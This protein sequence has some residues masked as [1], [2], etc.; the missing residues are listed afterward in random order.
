MI[1][2]S[3]PNERVSVPPLIDRDQ[4]CPF[5]LKTYVSVT[6]K[7]LPINYNSAAFNTFKPLC[8]YSWRDATLDELT[9]LLLQSNNVYN[10]VAT[11]TAPANWRIYYSLVYPNRDGR[12]CFNDIGVVSIRRV[13]NA[14][15]N[16]NS[17]VADSNDKDTFD[18]TGDI[19][20][21]LHSGGIEI[22]DYLDVRLMAVD[23]GTLSAPYN[24]NQT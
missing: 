23:D 7:D 12:F 20:M 8:I 13:A 14:Q 17:V 3:S 18:I 19:N 9:D 1:A 10:T 21:T 15:S 6:G 4:V 2:S 5:L 11:P 16:G 22:G 24:N